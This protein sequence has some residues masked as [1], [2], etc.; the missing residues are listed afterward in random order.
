MSIAKACP[1]CGIEMP[2]EYKCIP[3]KSAAILGIAGIRI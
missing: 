1:R 3:F 2:Q